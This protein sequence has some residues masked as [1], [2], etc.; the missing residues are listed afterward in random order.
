[1]MTRSL[2]TSAL[3][4]GAFLATAAPPQA[5]ETAPFLG[6]WNITGV[7]PDTSYV[8]W[9]E[10][11]QDAGAFSSLFLNRTG[12]PLPLT[13]V[14]IVNGELV[15][16]ASGTAQNPAG[17]VFHAKVVD[18]KLVGSFTSAGRPGAAN[19][20]PP[21]PRT[22]NWVGVRPPVWPAANANGPHEYGA[23]VV[24]YDEGMKDQDPAALFDVQNT[25][26]PVNWFIE[27]G[28]LTNRA[29]GGNNI[30]SKQTFNDFKVHVEYR[31]EPKS[32]SGIYLRGRYELQVLDDATDTTTEK[33]LMQGAIYGRRAPDVMASKAP[34]E[35]QTL[36]AVMVANRVTVRVN[37]RLVHD[38]QPVGGITGG[39][40]DCDELAPGPLMIQGDHGRIWIRQAIVTPII[41]AAPTVTADGMRDAN[42]S[43]R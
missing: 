12:H 15:F 9:L 37:G 10:L 21:A 20:T 11:Q 5:Q 22:V 8:Y 33:F 38:N 3:L 2:Q 36:D 24:L 14:K 27:D 31:L 6:Q 41:K 19:A 28:L 16:Q 25:L 39:A 23:P 34:G 32:N 29:P 7:P 1:M 43:R 17:P 42:T 4:L 35:W 30:I 13:A 18:G 40:L 26:R